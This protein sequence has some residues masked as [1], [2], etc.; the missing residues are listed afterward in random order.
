MSNNFSASI[1]ATPNAVSTRG[2]KKADRSFWRR[3]FDAWV[4]SYEHR[5]D[6]EGNV[7]CEL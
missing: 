5:M 6:P 7:F 3:L 1:G 2:P 4:R